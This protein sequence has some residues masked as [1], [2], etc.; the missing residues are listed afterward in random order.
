MKYQDDRFTDLSRSGR[1]WRNSKSFGDVFFVIEGIMK[2]FTVILIFTVFGVFLFHQQLLAENNS[3]HQG[4]YHILLSKSTEDSNARCSDG[5]DNDRDSFIDCLDSDCA[6][7][8]ICTNMCTNS[9]LDF[10]EYWTDCG[11]GCGVCPT[12]VDGIKNGSETGIDCGGTCLSCDASGS[13]Q[14][15]DIKDIS[16]YSYNFRM[17]LPPGY[18]HSKS[19]PL[20]IFLHG[21][22]ERGDDLNKVDNHGPLK[23]VNDDWWNYDFVIIAPQVP[24]GGDWSANLIKGLYD[25]VKTVYTGIDQNRVYITGL[26]MGGYGVDKIMRGDT[27]TWVTANAEICGGIAT[28]AKACNYKDTPS[29]SF[30]CD[31]DPTVKSA[32][33]ILNWAKILHGENN[34]Y[35]CGNNE[36]NPRIKIS[37]F[38]CNS[39]NSWSRVYDPFKNQSEYTLSTDREVNSLHQFQYGVANDAPPIYDWFLNS[40]K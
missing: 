12:C 9:I 14:I 37:L 33:Q 11:G 40:K 20:L 22:G 13:G 4:S 18:A 15:V 10:G 21:A 19:F 3:S 2:S 31:Y 16:Q 38:D 17:Y 23:H 25:K 35:S 8:D 30:A 24:S 26:S 29:W 34:T 28:N 39:H 36:L 32:Y 5:R 1:L 7:T 6:A 27:N